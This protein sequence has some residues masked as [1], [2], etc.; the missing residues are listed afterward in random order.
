[1]ARGKRGKPR[2]AATRRQ[3]AT[4][5]S[6]RLSKILENPWSYSESTVD[7]AAA[8]MWLIGRRHRIGLHPKQRIWICRGCKSPLRPGITA[9]I[10]I[11]R[12][13]R[14]TTCNK[15]GRIS[16]RGPDFPQEVDA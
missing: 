14:I 2:A 10:R 13:C 3:R 6:E 5:A 9:R 8:Q 12:G 4:T 15:C 16:R 11:R 7:Q 1:M